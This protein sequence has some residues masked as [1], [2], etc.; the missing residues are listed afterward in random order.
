MKDKDVSKK[1]GVT[2][3]VLIIFSVIF[4]FNNS[5]VAFLKMGYASI[6]WYIF[7][8]VVFFLP[9]MFI[10]AEYAASFKEDGGGIY[11]WMRKSR[12]ELYGFMGTFMCYFSILIV[13][14]GVSARIWVWRRQNKNMETFW[15]RKFTNS[16]NNWN[17]TNFSNNI[18]CNKRF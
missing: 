17:F 4:G 12:G 11:T 1:L 9:F 15:A 2:S 18:S 5:A 10:S 6:I 14:V 7:G 16:W 13:L 3:I 8:A